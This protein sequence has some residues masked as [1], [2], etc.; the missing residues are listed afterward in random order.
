MATQKNKFNVRDL[1]IALLAAGL[2]IETCT[3]AI[4]WGNQ[5]SI[6]AHAYANTER[7]DLQV[8]LLEQCFEDHAQTCDVT[9]GVPGAS[10]YR[11]SVGFQ[12]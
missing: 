1:I 2:I 11:T 4:F 6:N 9:T 12:W 3:F 8:R 5:N 10:A 7:T